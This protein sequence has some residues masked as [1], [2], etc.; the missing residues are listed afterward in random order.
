MQPV[1]FQFPNKENTTERRRHPRYPV[2][3]DVVIQSPVAGSGSAVA[4]DLCLGG[5]RLSGLDQNL[6]KIMTEGQSCMLS[7]VLPLADTE[8][9]LML[10]SHVVRVVD[11]SL[12]I[13]FGRISAQ[14]NA[15]IEQYIQADLAADAAHPAP[16]FAGVGQAQAL[17]Q[18]ITARYVDSLLMQLFEGM[19]NA[20]WDAAEHASSDAERSRI[21]GDASLFLQGYRADGIRRCKNYLFS[22]AVPAAP[23]LDDDDE[24]Q[25]IDEEQF[26]QWLAHSAMVAHLE[27]ELR[28]SLKTVRRQAIN[29]FGTD[30]ALV[31]QPRRLAD[32]I[33]QT[34]EC[35]G[36]SHPTMSTV[37]RAA[38]R[39]LP[40]LL[41][42]YYHEIN[43]AWEEIGLLPRKEP[44]KISKAPPA[45]V[46]PA[47][48]ADACPQIEQGGVSIEPSTGGEPTL[49]MSRASAL[50]MSLPHDALQYAPSDVAGG[51]LTEQTLA[52]MAKL[53]PGVDEGALDSRLRERLAATDRMLTH[54]SKGSAAPEQ[55]RDWLKPLALRFL[56][57]S[58]N[59]PKFFQD[60]EHA[61]LKVLNQLEQLAI[62][63]PSKDGSLETAV[64]A[65]LPQILHANPQDPAALQPIMR[66]ME[67]LQQRHAVPLQRQMA[68]VIAGLEGRERMHLA[69]S[70]V[71]QRLKHLLG[72][73]KV[74]RAVLALIET[75]WEPLL[76]V[77]YLREG[78]HGGRLRQACKVLK[79]LHIACGGEADPQ[80]M[81]I[82]AEDVLIARV[83]AELNY[84]GNELSLSKRLQ[85]QLEQAV[86]KA[87]DKALNDAEFGYY[88]PR[89]DSLI[90]AE[91]HAHPLGTRHPAWQQAWAQSGDAAIGSLLRL[92]DSG[93]S[94]L[95]RLV[96]RNGDG[97]QLAF[98]DHKSGDVRSFSRAELTQLL[99][100]ESST[101]SSAPQ[102]D[103]VERATEATLQEM[104]QRVDYH[105]THDPL[106]GLRN[107]MQFLGH[108]TRL[109]SETAS[110]DP[111]LLGF[112]DI[113]H[114]NAITNTCGYSAGEKMLQAVAR[115]LENGFEDAFCLAVLSTRRFGFIVK[116][117]PHTDGKAIGEG[118]NA[119][120]AAL[121]FYWRG[122][123][124]PMS[125]SI[126]LVMIKRGM[127]YPDAL[128]C[129][130][131][132]ACSSAREAG[133]HRV[134][135]FEEN[136][137]LIADKKNQMNWLIL[138]EDVL[139]AER[140]RLRGQR[141][142]PT[143]PASG[144]TPHYE[145]LLSVF[146][147]QGEPLPLGDFIATAEAFNLMVKVD[148]LV[149][150][151]ALTWVREHQEQV[152]ALGG[153]AINLSGK[154]LADAGLLA[155]LDEQIKRIGVAPGMISFEVTETAAIASI[156][157]A[158]GI[159]QGIK[160]MGCSVALDD[161]GT[162]LSSYT[163]LKHL[164][165][166][167]LKIDGSF[168]KNILHSSHDHAIVK[169]MNEI[170][171][172]MGKKT[173]AEYVESP[174]IM[175]QLA[176]MGVDYVQGYAVEKPRFLDEI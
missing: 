137:E 64:T 3:L 69:H 110:D 130:A 176:H 76:T 56:A 122:K 111:Y 154:S 58:V 42:P 132:M 50:L 12:G 131:D 166:D 43:H 124:Y 174:E 2:R 83:R 98:V 138:V 150:R 142:A 54:L 28:D 68:R 167:Y 9:Q 170:A 41:M 151:E 92:G 157:K 101:L 62:L 29:A 24:L 94:S 143:N 128:L 126:G 116:V 66:Q 114:F 82:L 6:A 102:S 121:P 97:S 1:N 86:R 60:A 129:A 71:A 155:Y 123:P 36:L 63:T 96:W 30:T 109:L 135:V 77:L 158:V 17:L 44:R 169:S 84:L 145:I 118:I 159:V 165:V 79:D 133:G 52:L 113:D 49:N 103:L 32:V 38:Q 65:L 5:A 67:D 48:S 51:S 161:F 105:Q 11:R 27:Q 20:L 35:F 171:H 78:E 100:A 136:S 125:G 53:L 134:L 117:P 149:I 74:H 59:D 13:S 164:P 163:Y 88:L 23:I 57:A 80:N 45:A 95:W 75:L 73:K 16:L 14:A 81:R 15:L 106:T 93:Q 127:D 147:T 175:A 37:W 119:Q 8:R 87:R 115:L 146:D 152:M 19:E 46:A 99:L 107:R 34:M 148:R 144:L 4:L 21:S 172:F 153:V 160:D 104:Q 89:D 31:L 25:L 156:E 90:A 22:S 120:L 91:Q 141:I 168:V 33:G 39:L 18:Q 61:L 108:L 173:I 72:G 112:L 7:L 139:K 162:G 55:L 40:R 140:I 10:P 47:P 70:Q 85:E 26:E